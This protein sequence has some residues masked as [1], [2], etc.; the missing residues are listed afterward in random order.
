MGEVETFFTSKADIIPG[1][2]RS[3][4]QT[5]ESINLCA[6]LSSAKKR[7]LTMTIDKRYG[8]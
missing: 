4:A 5:L 7:K 1:Y 3:L 2:E 8:D 6:A